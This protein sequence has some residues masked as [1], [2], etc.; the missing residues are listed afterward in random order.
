MPMMAG[1]PLDWPTPILAWALPLADAAEAVGVVPPQVT[2]NA[3]VGVTLGVVL[4]AIAFLLTTRIGPDLV[5]LG[6]LTILLVTGIVEPK[7]AFAGFGNEGLITVAIMF[8]V[9]EG[10]QQTGAVAFL[11]QHVLGQ[12]KSRASAQTRVMLP[13]AA[14]SAF[15]NNTP[16]VA[17]LMP[18][19][20]D[21][22]KKCRL[23]VSQLML[24]LSYAA[25]L[26]GL[27]TL[28]GTST[29]LV[30]N[31]LLIDAGH[32]SL[33][34][35]EIGKVGLPCA[36]VGIIYVLATSAWLLPNRKPVLDQLDDPREYTVEMLVEA[37][38]P[39]VGKS[40]EVA[41]LRHLPGMYLM[42]IEREG[43]ILAAVSPKELLSAGDRLVFVGVVESVVDL[44]RIPGLK[45]ATNQVFKLDSPRSERC[46]IEAVVSSTCP[47]VHRTIREAKFRT[48]YNAAVIAVSRNGERLRGKIGDITLVPGDTLLLEAHATFADLQRNSRDFYLVSRIEGSTPPKYE[49]AWIAQAVMVG[50]VLLVT[51][52]GVGMLEA[53]LLAAAVMLATRCVSPTEAKGA[54][55]WSILITMGAGIGIGVAM[56]AQHSRAGEFVAGLLIGFAGKDEVL[57]LAIVYGITMVFS[58]LITAKAAGVLVF[59]VALATAATL[60]VSFLPFAIAVMVAAAASLALPIGYQTNLMVFGPGGYRYSDYVRFGTP[61]SVILWAVSIVII[62][63]MWP[64]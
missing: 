28:I 29:T 38:S 27:C 44:Q 45:P 63:Q 59:P 25:I 14:M 40:I 60:D 35:F 17:I 22:A 61:L 5:L 11:I 57:A 23:P 52:F 9:A 42:E 58:N 64:F 56:D 8:V 10:L 33:S 48:R 39:L 50:L 21:W 32:E 53:S 30:L 62:P 19:L 16:V 18:V 20:D 2:F 37:G 36:V 31:G 55:D 4:C 7:A 13:T 47:V 41:G 49:L 54:I 46:L 12:P 34:L 1:T 26:G 6:C 51:V 15:L 24:P 43:H 3:E